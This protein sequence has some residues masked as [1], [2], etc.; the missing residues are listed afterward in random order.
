MKNP[1]IM[2]KYTHP[3][4]L[5]FNKAFQKISIDYNKKDKDI[6]RKILYLFKKTEDILKNYNENCF[7]CHNLSTKNFE[8]NLIR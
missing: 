7:Y 2:N 5:Y 6:T 3:T 1:V 4:L 8:S